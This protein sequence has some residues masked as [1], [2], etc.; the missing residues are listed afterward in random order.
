MSINSYTWRGPYVRA[1]LH[2]QHVSFL[3][4]ILSWLESAMILS[5]CLCN[6]V[7]WQIQVTQVGG[8][9]NCIQ[10]S[11][12]NFIPFSLW[13]KMRN[14]VSFQLGI[15]IFG[16]FKNVLCVKNSVAD[17][18]LHS[19]SFAILYRFKQMGDAKFK[20]WV[21]VYFCDDRFHWHFS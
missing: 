5:D 7:L 13:Q 6:L 17:C 16:F 2:K 19:L 9:L 3:L 1:N 20:M 8:A 10:V 11:C 18:L 14:T 4:F 12:L 15:P 21:L